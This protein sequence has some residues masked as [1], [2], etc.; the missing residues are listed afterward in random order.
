MKTKIQ[1]LPLMLIASAVL[2]FTSCQKESSLLVDDSYSA[3]DNSDVS[4]AL[5]YSV[6]DAGNVADGVEA[7]SGKT[8]GMIGICGADIDTSQKS[9]GIVVINYNGT[10]CPNG[11]KRT[12]SITLT[13]QGYANGSRWKDQGTVLEVLFDSVNVSKLNG[14]SVTLNGTHFL[15]NETGGRPGKV[16][17]GLEPGPVAIRHT[18]NNFSLTLPNGA[19]R[20]WSVNRLRTYTFANGIKTITLSSDH[21][22]G[23]V[24][25]A[26]S[27]GTNRN[28]V[29]FINSITT[30]LVSNNNCGW[31]K[32]VQGEVNHNVG[33][34]NVNVV[35][36]VDNNGN[37]ISSGCAYGF[38]I[39]YTKNGIVKTR[40]VSYWF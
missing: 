16:M 17:S 15:T 9:A 1:T 29:S 28:G 33:T 23:G 35:F 27:W 10:V 13:V 14:K 2:F 26:D 7:L 20:T 39:T 38:K 21:T 12:G 3:E 30:P 11:I 37:P 5:D 31:L 34:K 4:S 24:V 8:D 36:G 6:D 18:A 22:E 40:V 32:P 19:Q 25:N